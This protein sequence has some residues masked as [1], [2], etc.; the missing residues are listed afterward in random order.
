[1][2]AEALKLRNRFS[3]VSVDNMNRPDATSAATLFGD[4][5]NNTDSERIEGQ[6]EAK[7]E[8]IKL[9]LGR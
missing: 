9:A 2:A 6:A 1:L 3:K 4:M 8:V 7:P 5:Q